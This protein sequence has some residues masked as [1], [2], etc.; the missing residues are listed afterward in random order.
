MKLITTLL[1]KLT[2]GS[3]AHNTTPNTVLVKSKTPKVIKIISSKKIFD[4]FI[5]VSLIP[6]M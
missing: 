1:R 5:V 3:I 2:V 4:L 6:Q